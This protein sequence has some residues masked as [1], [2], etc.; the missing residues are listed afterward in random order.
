MGS[1]DPLPP[2]PIRDGF[3]GS[4]RSDR[5]SAGLVPRRVDGASLDE[6][7]G[8]EMKDPWIEGYATL[9]EEDG[10]DAVRSRDEEGLEVK[11]QGIDLVVLSPLPSNV[12]R[13]WILHPFRPSYPR[14][15]SSPRGSTTSLPLRSPRSIGR[16]R[17]EDPSDPVRP[18]CPVVGG[19]RCSFSLVVSETDL[20]KPSRPDNRRDARTDR[21]ERS[22]RKGMPERQD[23]GSN[24]ATVGDA[25]D[26]EGKGNH[27]TQEDEEE[28]DVTRGL[29]VCRICMPRSW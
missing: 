26:V 29:L 17:S 19:K 6:R 9:V 23:P 13:D 3:G 1:A 5:S 10:S 27:P 20:R 11:E 15:G 8:A 2:R 12:E 24:P 28:S 4:G 14:S 7:L 16:H 21:V 18:W 25:F 22:R